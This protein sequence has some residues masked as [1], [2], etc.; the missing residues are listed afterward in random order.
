[1]KSSG[2]TLIELLVVVAIIAV[3][4]AMLLPALRA[5]REAGKSAMCKANLKQINLG[6]SFYVEDNNGYLPAPAVTDYG[7]CWDMNTQ[8][9]KYLAS[10]MKYAN[11]GEDEKS[12]FICPSDAI[13]RT[14]NPT[15]RPQ[16]IK[17][18]YSMVCWKKPGWDWAYH[19]SPHRISSFPE[20]SRQF[21]ATEWHWPG[22][23]RNMPW[24]GCFIS[25]WYWRLGYDKENPYESPS[26]WSTSYPPCQGNYHG[27]GINNYLFM[28][29]HAASLDRGEADRDF[30]WNYP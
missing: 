26:N 4:V 3:L 11:P 25:K 12:L 2:F 27:P 9:G 29:G 8:L 10:N 22:N 24:A 21:L 14:A 16:N 18:S 17:R 7:P 6:F 28:D 20:P 23:V 13:M 1:M 30:Y 5:A 19:N 15:L